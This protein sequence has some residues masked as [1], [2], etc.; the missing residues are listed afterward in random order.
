MKFLII[1]PIAIALSLVT[2]CQSLRTL[3]DAGP[4]INDV[5]AQTMPRAWQERVSA[6]FP[7]NINW[8]SLGDPVLQ[9]LIAQGLA[10][11]L[12]MKNAYLSL[13]QALISLE[14]VRQGQKIN[15]GISGNGGLSVSNGRRV[16]DS[17]S[18]SASAS[19]EIDFWNRIRAGVERQELSIDNSE[20]NLKTLRIS[21]AA[22]IASLY[23]SLRVQDEILN[24]RRR[25][26]TAFERWR[27]LQAV[28]LS[29]GAI[30][31]LGID[32][33]DADIQNRKSAIEDFIARRQQTEQSLAIVLGQTPQDFR[34]KARAI[35]MFEIPR[36]TPDTPSHVL[37]AR[38]D[39]QNAERSIEQ[40][41][42]SLHIART[43]FLPTFSLSANTGTASNDLLKFLSL[44][45]ISRSAA[46]SVRQIFLDNGNRRRNVEINEIA[47]EQS[48]NRYQNT[49]LSA[50]SD[51]ETA[52]IQQGN[53]I[54][55]IEIL[56]SQAEAQ[57]RATKL[58]ETLYQ[59]G[60]GDAFD[61]IREQ[62]SRLSLQE[63]EIRNWQ[64][65]INIS[66]SLL[67]A[68]G[69]DPDTS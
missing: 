34:L 61:F 9:D 19:Y 4:A 36:L 15:Y 45:T 22:S 3:P 12:N 21:T 8:Q 54:R 62:Q 35:D 64:Q 51:V 60:T 13:D 27:E 18:L 38:P 52:L 66:V 14:G 16:A 44:D 59:S 23:F 31:R 32:Q 55:Q 33:L 43:A 40:A 26:L 29:A 65:G 48:L 41:Y 37:V 49:I 20:S 46:A 68:L 56:K 63:R 2:G 28:R 58:T 42:L 57:D 50:L 1:A 47:I 17:Y 10:N 67:R 7:A 5:S 69:V 24:L 6:E 30:T 39:I 11:N 25:S 53:N